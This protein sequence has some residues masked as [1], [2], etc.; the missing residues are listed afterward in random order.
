[1]LRL[2]YVYWEQGPSQSDFLTLHEEQPDAETAITPILPS[3]G[4]PLEVYLSQCGVSERAINRIL[5][6]LCELPTAGFDLT[7]STFVTEGERM[8]LLTVVIRWFDEVDRD[9]EDFL[10]RVVVVRM[11]LTKK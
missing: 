9:E 6:E 10:E 11:V 7:A 8:S 1:M 3:D 2:D 5:G 4:Q